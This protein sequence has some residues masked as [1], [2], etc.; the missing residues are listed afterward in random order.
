MSTIRREQISAALRDLMDP[1]FHSNGFDRAQ[2]KM[3]VYRRNVGDALQ[4]VELTVEM[5]PGD[6]AL[7]LAAIYP[8]LTV[9]MP[10]VDQ[11]LGQMTADDVGLLPG[12]THGILR[13][14][15][16][17][18]SEK[19]A[20]GRW[21][22]YGIDNL[23]VISVLLSQFLNEW[24]LPFLSDYK[25]VTDILEADER[26]DGRVLRDRAQMLRVVAAAYLARG[27]EAASTIMEGYFG[28]PGLRQRYQRVFEYLREH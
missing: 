11:L 3:P 23:P 1:F 18:T 9:S 2:N 24:T 19:R 7:A 12:V 21:Y 14:P 20:S 28:S 26:K 25:F 16:E 4:T 5:R 10:E 8:W 13:Q 15:I 17:F 6:D 27:R 22:V